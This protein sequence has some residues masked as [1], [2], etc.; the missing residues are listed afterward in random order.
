MYAECIATERGVGYA[1]QPLNPS[2]SV[3]KS[4]KLNTYEVFRYTFV[5]KKPAHG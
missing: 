5:K 2:L 3:L 4:L 1:F